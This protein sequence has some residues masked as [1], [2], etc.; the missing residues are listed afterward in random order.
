MHTK[1]ELIPSIE[2]ISKNNEYSNIDINN[3]TSNNNSF[4]NIFI[5]SNIK[6]EDQ[7]YYNN[8]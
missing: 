1:N 2:P 5:Q 4:S 8:Y 7:I 6:L 3:I